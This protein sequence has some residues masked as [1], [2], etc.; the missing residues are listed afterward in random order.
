MQLS[1]R[2]KHAAAV[3]AV[4]KRRAWLTA[5]DLTFYANRALPNG[6][7]HMTTASATARARDF[8]K[9][10]YGGHDVRCERSRPGF[11]APAYKLIR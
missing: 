6:I 8:R 7:R 9:P 2:A 4:L 11:N 10:E 3:W 5:V 1:K